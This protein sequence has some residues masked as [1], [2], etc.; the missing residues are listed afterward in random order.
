MAS[1]TNQYIAPHQKQETRTGIGCDRHKQQMRI[2][3]EMKTIE[4]QKI[5]ASQYEPSQFGWIS[6]I[7][8]HSIRQTMATRVIFC[9]RESAEKRRFFGSFGV[10]Q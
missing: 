6:S 7:R 9:S 4:H 10:R 3:T 8:H 5:Y 1:P 2:G